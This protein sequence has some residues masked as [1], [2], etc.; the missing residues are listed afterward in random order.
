MFLFFII[1]SFSKNWFEELFGFTESVENVY[2]YISLNKTENGIIIS[3]SAFN[4]PKLFNSG[5]FE[6]KSFSCFNFTKPRGNGR[7]HII[8]GTKNP[9]YPS[10][11]NSLTAQS[12]PENNGATFQVASNFNCLEFVSKTQTA[13]QGIKNYIYDRTQGPYCAI[14]TA[15]SLLYR[16]YFVEMGNGEIGQINQ[17][18]N[19][20][21]KTPFEI[22]HGYPDVTNLDAYKTF[23][24]DDYE[25]YQ[26]GSHSNCEVLIH[27]D[28]KNNFVLVNEKQTVHQVFC[29]ALDFGGSLSVRDP[30]FSLIGK[31]I[32][33]NSYRLTILTAWE[34]S[35]KY[36][37][38]PGSNKVYLT[39]LGNGVFQNPIEW[40]YQAI[41][42][43][44]KL[45]I[46]SGLDIYLVFFQ[47]F[48]NQ[49]EKATEILKLMEKTHGTFIQESPNIE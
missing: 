29:A 33:L 18:I 10:I 3:S 21:S 24:W 34:N 27:Q 35:L 19:L 7:F 49:N 5:F 11:S 12:I 4:P 45:I 16:N 43:N 2:K 13:S 36:P 26:I 20:L 17:N 44:E 32:L 15:A 9:K 41:L 39:L 6:L 31:Q 1:F 38:L 28:K 8:S 22:F 30:I 42:L 48:N 23:N 47:G 37:N 40:V 46:E 25:K 14:A